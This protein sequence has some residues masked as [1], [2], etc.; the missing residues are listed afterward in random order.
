MTLTKLE[1]EARKGLGRNQ[2]R[3]M[4]KHDD[5]IGNGQLHSRIGIT[6]CSKD[7][8]DFT[9]MLCLSD[10]GI[11]ALRSPVPCRLDTRLTIVLSV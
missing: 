5:V 10:T 1:E 9:L 4:C 7:R 11:L 8:D 2:V 3:S 6:T